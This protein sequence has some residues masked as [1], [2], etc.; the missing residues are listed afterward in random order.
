[1]LSRA[2]GRRA[3][4]FT[5]IITACTEFGE[6]HDRLGDMLDEDVVF[7][8]ADGNFICKKCVA[9]PCNEMVDATLADEADLCNEDKQWRIIGAQEP[10]LGH[11]DTCDHCG[12]WTLPK[13]ADADVPVVEPLW[14]ARKRECLR[15]LDV[16]QGGTA[17][18]WLVENI[19]RYFGGDC[20]GGQR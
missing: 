14:E 18:W 6:L 15:D 20:D 12:A 3:F 9:M 19:D 5:P 7:V 4:F 17:P 16:L 2:D 13:P 11:G 10:E 8:A 1:M